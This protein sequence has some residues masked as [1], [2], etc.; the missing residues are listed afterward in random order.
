VAQVEGYFAKHG[1]PTPS[2]TN[3]AHHYVQQIQ[4]KSQL[5]I[6]NWHMAS[7][8][9]PNVSPSQKLDNAQHKDSVA[10]A[11]FRNV[12]LGLGKSKLS[13]WRQTEVL[14]RRTLLENFKNKKKFFRGI[15]SRL[16]ASIMVGLFFWQMAAVPTQKSIFP[17]K[18]VV[19]LCTQN[20][21]IESFY[22]GATTFQLTKG[23]L[24][25]EYYDGIYQVTP[26]YLAYYLGF[27]AMQIPWTLAWAA[28]LYLFV[29]L[30]LEFKRCGIFLL[31]TF[32]MLLMACAAGS[33]VGAKTRDA[34][35]NRA[36]LMPMLIPATL[37]SGYVIPYTQIPR[38]WMFMYYLSPMQWGM[39]LLETSHYQGIVFPDCDASLPYEDRR[40]W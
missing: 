32:L 33:A 23:L 29:G 15:M 6:D 7:A 12:Q 28:P 13:L 26:Y 18:G 4:D 35:G 17:L 20:P 25:R 8:C 19:F 36:V 31:T 16:P 14:T 40:C 21:M 34:D 10:F 27:L 37:F 22:A 1:S 9:E 2:H 39:T 24:K 38:I 30:P 3:P 11:T 5:W